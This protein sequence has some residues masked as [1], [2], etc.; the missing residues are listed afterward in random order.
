MEFCG[1]TH[2]DNTAKAGTFRIKS[3]GSVASGVRRSEA[4]V[5]KQTKEMVERNQQLLVHAAQLLKTSPADLESKI[6]QQ[7]AEIKEMKQII[8]KLKAKEF[9]GEAQQYLL[10]AKEI[11][12]LKVVA[13]TKPELS[14]D[15]LRKLGDFMRDKA[16]DVVALLASVN[17]EK[18][19]FLAVCGKDAIAKGVKAGDIIK[20]IAPIC[21]GKGGGKPDSAMG[22]GSD[23][24]KLDDAMAALDDFVAGKVQ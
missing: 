12:G 24:L 1:G 21:G 10:S 3:E 16:S 9:L 14:A 18:I 5:G 20:T 19:T 13:L 4:T 2:L 23:V 6:E 22:G 7:L 15:D 8:E 17:G 11:K